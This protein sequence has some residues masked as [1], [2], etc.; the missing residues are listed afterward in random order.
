[1]LLIGAAIRSPDALQALFRLMARS[2]FVL[3]PEKATPHNST[4]EDLWTLLSDPR[5]DPA[6]VPEH[7]RN[8]YENVDPSF[9]PSRTPRLDR[10]FTAIFLT[11][12]EES[13]PEAGPSGKSRFSYA[14]L[15]QGR[16]LSVSSAETRA[17][18]CCRLWRASRALHRWLIKL[19]FASWNRMTFCSIGAASSLRSGCQETFP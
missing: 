8:P 9:H 15:C 13:E 17:R 14:P 1:M 18:N 7:R 11:A 10:P 2:I 3:A 4:M 12:L 16:A 6:Y 19:S 5:L